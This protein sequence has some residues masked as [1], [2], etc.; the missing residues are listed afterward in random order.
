MKFFSMDMASRLREYVIYVGTYQSFRDFVH[1]SYPN[2]SPNDKKFLYINHQQA[3]DLYRIRGIHSAYIYY[4]Y[5][6]GGVDPEVRRELT[7]IFDLN[8]EVPFNY[9]SIGVI[10]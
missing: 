6:P 3:R 10:Q 4:G 2:V 5:C 7:M 1:C 8:D 9:L